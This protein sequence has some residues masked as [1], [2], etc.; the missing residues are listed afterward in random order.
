MSESQFDKPTAHRPAT[1]DDET[2]THLSGASL[3]TVMAAPHIDISAELIPERIGS[4]RI[5]RKIGEGGMGS[6]YEA[7]QEN[8]RRRVALKV[9]RAGF[10]STQVLRRFELEA[11][12]LGR[13]QHPGIAQVYEAGTADAGH[14]LQPFFAMEYIDGL[15]LL[16]YVSAQKLGT[17][18]RLE[19]VAKICDAVQHAHQKGVI[20]RDLKP[21]NILVV[22][23][24]ATT[25][26]ASMTGSGAIRSTSGSADGTLSTQPKIL[27][28]GIARATDSDIQVTTMH[29]DV[30]QLIGTIPYMSPEQVSGD[31]QLLDTRSDVYALGVIAYEVLAGQLPYEVRQKIIPEAVRIIREEDPSPLSSINRMFR[32]DV[33]TIVA[34]SLEK[35]KLRRYQSAAELAADI[36]RYLR[37]E[38]IVARPPSTVYQIRKFARRNKTLVG[39]VVA[40]FIVLVA[41]MV[42]STGQY[43]KAAAARD[44]ARRERDRAVEAE[45][46]AE[47]N[48]RMAG[49]AVTKYFTMVGDSPDLKARGLEVLRRQLL[50]TARG[51]YDRFVQQRG[52]DP[53]L[54]REL[55]DALINLGNIDRSIGELDKAESAQKRAGEIGEALA[56]QSPTEPSYLRLLAIVHS[57]L[58]L[59]YADVNRAGESEAAYRRAIEL[60]EQLAELDSRNLADRSRWANAYDNFGILLFATAKIAEAEDVYRKGMAI[61]E[62][63][64]EDD[65][66]NVSYRNLL[67]HSYNNLSQLLAMTGRAA[68][69]EPFLTKAVPIMRQLVHEHPSVPDYQRVLASTYSNLAGVYIL[70]DRLEQA[71]ETYRRSLSA[72]EKL[73]REHPLVLEYTLEVGSVHCNLGELDTRLGRADAALAS[74]AVAIENM[75]RVLNREPRHATARYYLSYTR[76]WRARAMADLSRWEDA[77]ADWDHAIQ[78]DDRNDPVLRSGRALA[79][80]QTGD[81]AGAAAVAETLIDD[82][83]LDAEGSFFLAAAYARM[84][85]RSEDEQRTDGKSGDSSGARAMQLLQRAGD[86]GYFRDLE[87]L[88]RLKRSAAFNDLRTTESFLGLVRQF[89]AARSPQAVLPGDESP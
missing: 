32:G 39:G 29:T 60:E 12:V 83:R 2:S 34:K 28:F 70:T 71:R 26:A 9:I 22:D 65:P 63:I 31:P 17:R 19:L 43:L 64:V 7:E 54:Q 20:H 5:L 13:L 33:E 51:F 76:S 80:A 6:V 89:D 52:D 4:Y 36:R 38:P 78:L 25:T 49:E 84:A 61:R 46:L 58:G 50:D 37:D 74:F 62:K 45:K 21:G 47:E 86:A 18:Q 66:Q 68:N 16:D 75:E 14:G 24:G 8:P 44:E 87:N 73:A 1:N 15:T 57:N 48:F 10:V 59:I 69:A 72:R 42:I 77:L 88:R 56:A 67:V 41:G 79:L 40:V 55:A 82:K 81:L 35:D 85:A 23:E 11:Q 53:G 30:G 3:P 27:D